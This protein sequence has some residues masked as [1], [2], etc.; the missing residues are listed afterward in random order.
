MVAIGP[1]NLLEFF[2]YQDLPDIYLE[3][4]SGRFS[5]RKCEN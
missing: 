3:D 5:Q 1:A 4:F 2:L